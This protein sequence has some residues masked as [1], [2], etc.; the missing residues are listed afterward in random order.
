MY[1]N[2]RAWEYQ[3]VMLDCIYHTARQSGTA[4]GDILVITQLSPSD[5]PSAEP[6][7]FLTTS[8]NVY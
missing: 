4:A 2:P 3:S 5:N 8:G 1:F 7:L 6:D